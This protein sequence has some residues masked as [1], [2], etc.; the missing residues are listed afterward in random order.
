[1]NKIISQKV[2]SVLKEL[3][4]IRNPQLTKEDFDIEE[5]SASL[6]KRGTNQRLPFLLSKKAVIDLTTARNKNLINPNEQDNLRKTFAAFF[7]LSV[8]SHAALTWMMQSRADEILITDP[9]IISATNLNRIRSGWSTVGRYKVDV[10]KTQ[11]TDIHPYAKVYSYKK[12][13]KEKIIKNISRCNVII[14]EVDDLETKVLL[15]KVAKENK[16]PLISAADVG[17]NVI[18]DVERYDTDPNLQP[19]L[20]RVK[21]LELINF[22]KLTP[23]KKRKLIITLVGFEKNSEQM[24]NSLFAIGASV[25]SWPQLGATATIAG[26]IITTT[27]KKIILGEK[28]NSG[29]YYISL[30]DILNHDFNSRKNRSNR[31]FKIKHILKMLSSK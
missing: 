22:K 29:R 2:L 27:I 11:I 8:G 18:L 3:W 15:R 4:A 9:D 5:I 1:M 7:G 6:V 28:V 10:V 23:F 19:F 24:I 14:D 17:D 20:G 21:N 31:N 26:G 13:T 30:D 16:I 25:E 12:L